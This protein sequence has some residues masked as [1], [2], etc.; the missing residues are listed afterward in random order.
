MLQTTLCSGL[1][2]PSPLLL[3]SNL[4]STF[5]PA[6]ELL[7]L[8]AQGGVTIVGP[9]T[10]S[11]GLSQL[12][13]QLSTATLPVNRRLASLMSVRLVC[14]DDRESRS[15]AVMVAPAPRATLMLPAS[16]VLATVH[17]GEP[18]SFAMVEASRMLEQRYLPGCAGALRLTWTAAFDLENW[19]AFMLHVAGR[20]LPPLQ[21]CALIWPVLSSQA[22]RV[23]H[24]PPLPAAVHW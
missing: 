9:T 19:A 22:S 13:P 3:A 10:L 18:P 7:L 21:P 15:P 17:M 20:Q 11:C 2:E 16:L 23:L 4:S 5:E 8:A 14:D 1:P 6:A 12:A 24:V